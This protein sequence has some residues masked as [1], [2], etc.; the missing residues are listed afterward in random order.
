M[1]LRSFDG[2]FVN[3]NDRKHSKRSINYNIV[4]LQKVMSE[5]REIK[6]YDKLIL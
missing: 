6:I 3:C 5:K 2:A 1:V 4:L